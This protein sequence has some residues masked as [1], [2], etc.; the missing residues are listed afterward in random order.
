[1]ELTS[2]KVLYTGQV[3]D[4]NDLKEIG[5]EKLDVTTT[6]G[7]KSSGH[8]SEIAQEHYFSMCPPLVMHVCS[9]ARPGKDWNISRATAP[10][11]GIDAL[12]FDKLPD[13]RSQMM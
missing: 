6:S 8:T 3:V 12:F 7:H 10:N 1:M 11:F 5:A 2:S 9:R 13:W 4:V